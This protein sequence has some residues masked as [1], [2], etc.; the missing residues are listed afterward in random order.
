MNIYS[1][2]DKLS[3]G[4]SKQP[5]RIPFN[6]FIYST[7]IIL[8]L[9]SLT[10]QAEAKPK[11]DNL[12]DKL[13]KLKNEKRFVASPDAINYLKTKIRE[14]QE[15]GE[16]EIPDHYIVKLRPGKFPHKVINEG[17]KNAL[18]LATEDGE[19]LTEVAL[20]L[21]NQ[22]RGKLHACMQ[23]IYTGFS[24]QIPPEEVKRLQQNPLVEAIYPDSLAV[25]D[26]LYNSWGPDRIDQVAW[27][28]D[29]VYSHDLNGSGVNLYILGKGIRGSHEEFGNRVENGYHFPGAPHPNLDPDGSKTTKVTSIAAGE[30]YGVANGASIYSCRLDIEDGDPVHASR[31]VA[32]MD[33]IVDQYLN[34]PM[35]FLYTYT[36]TPN[37]ALDEAVRNAVAHGV[38]VVTSAGNDSI[39][40]SNTSPNRVNEAIVVGNVSLHDIKRSSSNFGDTVDVYAPGTYLVCADIRHDEDWTIATGTSYSAPVVAG[41]AAQY[42]QKFPNATPAQVETAIIEHSVKGR[43]TNLPEGEIVHNRIARSFLNSHL[44]LPFNPTVLTATSVTETSVNL[45]WIDNSDNENGFG[46]YRKISSGS[47]AE[48]ATVPGNQNFFSDNSV[49]RGSSYTY[50]VAAFNI[51]G[52]SGFSNE[53]TVTIPGTTTIPTA[54]SNLRAVA[55]VVSNPNQFVDYFRLQWNDN[56][57]NETGFKIERRIA[58]SMNPWHYRTTVSANTTIFYDYDVGTCVEFAYR[59]RALNGTVESSA[60]NVG[61]DYWCY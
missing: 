18:V 30:Y 26:Q 51:V 24:A 41:I 34:L 33:G 20:R 21:V 42:L 5:C 16:L 25:E 39:D 31:T 37:D 48:I 44:E 58:G 35:V 43:M 60:S 8:I 15:Q 28:L 22:H 57:S 12:V 49:L 2:K 6:L 38:V 7:L 23:R 27:P 11:D 4:R 54:P 10:F 50:K 59:V 40:A 17:S 14:A 47:Y 52:P 53:V 36:H 3:Q 1:G 13:E 56:S 45:S 9:F 46:I 55:Y 29:G 61:A 32:M 19:S